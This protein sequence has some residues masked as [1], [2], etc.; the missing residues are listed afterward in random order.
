[1][2]K[3]RTASQLRNITIE[4]GNSP[5]AEGSCIFNT[6][7]TSIHCTATVE[8]RIPPFLRG[9]GS[10]WITA[11]YSMLPRATHSRTERESARG[12][13]SGRT[14]EIQRLIGRSL[15]M[16]IDLSLLGERQI[17]IDCDTLVADGGTRTASINGGFHAMYLAISKLKKQGLISVNP[18]QKFIGAVSVGISQK[19]EVLLDLDY[20]EDST[21]IADA[22]FVLDEH[23]NIIEA[24]AS[25]EQNEVISKEIFDNMFSIAKGGINSIIKLQKEILL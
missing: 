12:K 4:S 11:E 15:R 21:C 7:K 20:N 19:G 24:Q 8:E 13:L 23:G 2:R 17:T 5:Y 22:N 10:G 14:Q 18:I 9:K 6:G 3:S 1:M 16:P 25:C